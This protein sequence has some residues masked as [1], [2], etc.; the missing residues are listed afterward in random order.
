MDL[1]KPFTVL[2]YVRIERAKKRLASRLAIKIMPNK[3]N[4][5]TKVIDKKGFNE[6][7]LTGPGLRVVKFYADW[8]GPC[9]MMLPIYNEL[10]NMYKGA[11]SFFSIDVEE[12]PSL[13]KELGVIE[14]PTILFYLNGTVVD[15]VNGLASRNSL[16]AKLE[17][18]LNNKRSSN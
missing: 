7:V 12:S 16:I 13:K 9:Q 2:H 11:A 10:A 8:S 17:N 3:K 1:A 6:K 18:L 15:F 5:M 4:D 14:M